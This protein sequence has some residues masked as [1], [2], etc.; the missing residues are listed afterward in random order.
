MSHCH[1]LKAARPEQPHRYGASLPTST[2][3]IFALRWHLIWWTALSNRAMSGDFLFPGRAVRRHGITF[4]DSFRIDP[5]VL[6]SF[7]LAAGELPPP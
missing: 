6:A 5:T 4:G 2:T 1:L 7:H 3:I